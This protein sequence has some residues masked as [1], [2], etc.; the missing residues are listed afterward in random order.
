MSAPYALH[1]GDCREVMA[2]ME[3]ESIDAIVTDPPYGTTEVGKGKRTMSGGAVVAFGHEWDRT[4]PTEWLTEAARVLKSGGAVLA[5]GDA[6]R[7]G[8]LWAAGEAAGLRPLQTFYWE[9]PDPPPNPRKNFA[10][11]VEVGVFFRKPGRV[12]F[13][14]GGGWCRNICKAPL[15]HKE[16]DGQTRYHPTEK[17]VSLMRWLVRIVTPPGGLVLDPFAG[18]GSTG[19]ACMAEGFRFVGIDLESRYVEIAERRL[20]GAAGQPSLFEAAVVEGG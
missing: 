2:T 14:G 15:A 11:A 5:F 7:P 6:K 10:S 12:L 8:E 18:S 9:K 4:M 20:A 19:V 1:C 13:W 17:P 16:H 3:A